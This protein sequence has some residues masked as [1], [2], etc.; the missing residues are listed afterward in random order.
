MKWTKMSKI[1]DPDRGIDFTQSPQA[2]V[3]PDF[4]RI[5]YSTRK[6][7]N[8]KFLSRVEYVDMDKDFN[9]VIAHSDQ[10]VILPGAA[11]HFD[12]HGIFPMNV[13]R[14]GERLVGYTTGWSRRKSVSVETAIG[15]VQS[16][17]DGKTF[18]RV[19]GSGPILAASPNEPFL[20]GDA[21]VK[22]FDGL[23]HMWYI[24][25]TRWI[26]GS[27]PERVYKIGHA[28]STDA[29]NWARD[30][31]DHIISNVWGDD[32]C[33]ALPTVTKIGDKYHMYFCY[34]Q[35]TD[36]RKNKDRGYRLGYAYSTDLWTWTR[37]DKLGGLD[38][39]ES[40]W[41]SEMMCYP[42]LFE[43]DGRTYML[44]NGNEFGRYGFGVARLESE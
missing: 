36:F 21:F 13:C 22:S 38:L 29:V 39:S 5:Y 27:Q 17:D 10:P 12:E 11:G 28:T 42:H 20:V 35:A 2:L 43:M 44:Y 34:R 19:Y 18:Q 7:D 41:D 32:E 1:F 23:F 4:V 16:Y 25:G 24:Y 31:G 37:D 6:P 30:G 26:E 9:R 33:Q 40:G 15:I 14:I 8:G 3:F